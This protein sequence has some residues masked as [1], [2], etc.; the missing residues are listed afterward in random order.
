MSASLFL[1]PLATFTVIEDIL[2]S[3]HLNINYHIFA[4]FTTL[5]N[6][7]ADFFGLYWVLRVYFPPKT[8]KPI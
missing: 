6:G 2:T 5:V 7:M 8:S 4:F 1:I 3:R